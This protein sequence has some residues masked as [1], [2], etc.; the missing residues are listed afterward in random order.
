MYSSNNTVASYL[1][2]Q[3]LQQNTLLQ[4]LTTKSLRREILYKMNKESTEV[5]YFKAHWE[6][7]TNSPF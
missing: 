7:L 1:N 6:F 2:L 5:C 3:Y 4:L